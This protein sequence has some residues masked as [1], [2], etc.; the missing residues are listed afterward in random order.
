MIFY[1][2][3]GL[4]LLLWMISPLPLYVSGL[5]GLCLCAL[6]E[7]A[8]LS[9]LLYGFAH[10]VIFLF[11]SGFLFARALEKSGL[12]QYFLSL[13]LK[14]KTFGKN[15][16]SRL[17]YLLLIAFTLSGW[18][19][20]TAT[21]AILLPLAFRLFDNHPELTSHRSFILLSLAYACAI[22][23]GLT[24]IGSPPNAIA[25]GIIDPAL[26]LSFFEWMLY[27]APL[28]LI[29]FYF[30]TK[31]TLKRI[32]IM[33]YQGSDFIQKKLS[34]SQKWVMS[35]FALTVA[36]WVIPGIFKLL[37][38]QSLAHLKSTTVGLTG[39]TL[40]FLFKDE[41]KVPIL[42][43]EDIKKIDWP[44]LFLFAEG[45]SLGALLKDNI[46]LS[47]LGLQIPILGLIV[48]AIFICIFLTELSSN[49]A[50]ASSVFPLIFAFTPEQYQAGLGLLLALACNSAFMLPIATP[51][52]TIVYGTGLVSK[53]EMATLGLKY[54]I[55]AATVFSLAAIMRMAV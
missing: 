7:V 43:G 13:G 32:P 52:N 16:R 12:D 19:S 15:S 10:P 21:M 29:L 5:I 30:L 35:I 1:L 34:S 47:P 41:N 18:I 50:I 24:P 11:L 8:P 49:T 28:C 45:I 2:I 55:L 33:E 17:L 20:N 31:D 42:E 44:S 25:Q 37:G 54:N 4:T 48:L 38:S 14:S 36:F 23:G 22:G 53:T 40:L 39:A 3:F 51:P 9:K 27:A 6:L 26:A 46:D